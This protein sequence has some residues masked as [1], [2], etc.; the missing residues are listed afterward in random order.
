MSIEEYRQRPI[1]FLELHHHEPWRL[2]LYSI[3]CKA[4]RVSDA[5]VEIVKSKLPSW[6]LRSTDSAL[7]N[8]RIGTVIIHEA[9]EGYFVLTNWWIDRVMLQNH[10]YQSTYDDPAHFSD[11]SA[12]GIIACAWELQVISF[13]TDA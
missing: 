3:S 2:K 6:L 9:R 8:D 11:F 12:S 1:R 10:T 7:A 4:E 13:E 5:I